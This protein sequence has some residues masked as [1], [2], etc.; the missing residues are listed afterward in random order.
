M[1]NSVPTVS[2]LLPVKNPHPRFFSAAVRSILEQSFADFELCLVEAPSDTS[3]G[4]LLSE[5]DDPR[6]RHVELA[7]PTTLVDQLNHGLAMA[8]GTFVARMDADDISRSDRLE[9]QMQLLK[10]QPDVDVVGSQ[11]DVIDEAGRTLGTRRYPVDHESIMTAMRRFN[12][13]AHPAVMFR[14]ETIVEAGGYRYPDRAAQD[15]E[16]WCR[17]A[18]LGKRFANHQEP[19]LKYRLHPG[20]I[21]VDR[22]RDTLRSTLATKQMY[23]R[24]SMTWHDRARMGLE[25]IALHAPAGLVLWAFRKTQYQASSTAPPDDNT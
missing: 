24:D 1:A 4:A 19:L 25:R 17:L 21:K 20:A 8:R 9:K 10:E 6:I 23:W 5:F 7:A 22:L 16:L 14:R 11:L 18:S 12:P 2:V 15:Y 13:L 3:A